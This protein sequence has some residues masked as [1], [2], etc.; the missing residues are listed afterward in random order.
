MCLYVAPLLAMDGMPERD[1]RLAQ[2]I[3]PASCAVGSVTCFVLVGRETDSAVGYGAITRRLAR[4][5]HCAG[6]IWL[7][8]SLLII[9]TSTLIWLNVVVDVPVGARAFVEGDAV[10]AYW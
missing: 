9:L 7:G 3:V 5:F 2:I 10:E 6:N 1:P 4:F 8:I